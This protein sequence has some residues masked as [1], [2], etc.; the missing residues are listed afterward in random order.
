MCI[1]LKESITERLASELTRCP[2]AGKFGHEVDG[3]HREHQGDGNVIDD[4]PTSLVAYRLNAY[5]LTYGLVSSSTAYST[6]LNMWCR[7][8]VLLHLSDTLL[9]VLAKRSL[10]HKH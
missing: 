8:E 7:P 6:A 9:T 3:D 2:A 10:R 5:A 4:G 1:G